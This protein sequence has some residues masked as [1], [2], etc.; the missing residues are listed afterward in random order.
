MRGTTVRIATIVAVIVCAGAAA[1][2]Q[3]NVLTHHNDNRRTGANL[4]ESTLTVANVKQKFGKLWQLYA[5]GQIVA[6]P[7]YVS[8]LRVDG[9]GTFNAVIVVTMHNT[10]YVYDADKRP[11]QPQARDALIWA[12]WLGDP[13]ATPRRADPR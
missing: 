4:Q 13:T 12:Q 2:A 8:G 3:V 7:L 5:D 11:T 9:K 6:Q 1:R 10:I